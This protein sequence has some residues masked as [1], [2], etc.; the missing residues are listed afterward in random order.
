[1]VADD[2][3]MRVMCDLAS[4]PF[5]SA[6]CMVDAYSKQFFDKQFISTQHI[7]LEYFGQYFVLLLLDCHKRYTI[8]MSH[9]SE[10]DG[11]DYQPEE[12]I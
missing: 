9:G 1:V 6:K 12:K 7:I 5:G 4:L 3:S 10:V 2:A 8:Q 11:T